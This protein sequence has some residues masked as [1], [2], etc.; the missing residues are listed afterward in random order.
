MNIKVNTGE[1]KRVVVAAVAA[2]AATP[3]IVAF[4]EDEKFMEKHLL[5]DN[6]RINLMLDLFYGTDFQNLT[7]K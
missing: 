6:W 3:A 4:L 2:I 1:Q 5:M 7:S